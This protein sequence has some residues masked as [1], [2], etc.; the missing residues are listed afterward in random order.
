MLSISV[1]IVLYGSETWSLTQR[2]ECRLRIFENRVLRRIS[3]L[4]RNKVTAEWRRR[5]NKELHALYSLQNINWVIKSRSLR[6]A[7]NEA[8]IGRGEVHTGF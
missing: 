7:E 1:K 2:E 5:H 8:C 3:E 6:W 4:K